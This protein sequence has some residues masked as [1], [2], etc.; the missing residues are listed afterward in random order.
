MPPIALSQRPGVV[1]RMLSMAKA[2]VGSP[3]VNSF[4][5]AIIAAVLTSLWQSHIVERQLRHEDARAA[6][7]DDRRKLATSIILADQISSIHGKMLGASHAKGTIYVSMLAGWSIPTEGLTRWD[8]DDLSKFDANFLGHYGGLLATLGT[9]NTLSEF[10][11]HM[12]SDQVA[13]ALTEAEASEV[14]RHISRAVIAS[15]YMTETLLEVYR[16]ERIPVRSKIEIGAP[17]VESQ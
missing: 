3:F 2:F 12:Y 14:R 8:T 13:A 10:Y 1:W 5:A 4:L 9:I 7:E 16:K 15:G 6:Q 11:A 17:A